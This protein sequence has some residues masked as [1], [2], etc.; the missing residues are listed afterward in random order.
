VPSIPVAGMAL[1]FGVD[2]FMS[3]CRALTNIIGNGVAT[4]VISAWERELDRAKLASALHARTAV[5]AA[6]LIPAASGE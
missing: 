2:K 3:E 1:I 6:D 5:S 4:I